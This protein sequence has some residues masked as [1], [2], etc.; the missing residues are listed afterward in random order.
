MFANIEYYRCLEYLKLFLSTYIFCAS[1]YFMPWA[2]AQA[3]HNRIRIG[4]I[5]V[6]YV[7]HR[8]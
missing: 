8:L 3:N 7:Y 2:D 6:N 5:Y 1:E 4:I